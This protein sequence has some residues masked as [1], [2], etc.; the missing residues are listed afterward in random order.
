MSSP[1]F[2]EVQLPR[3]FS[4]QRDDEGDRLHRLRREQTHRRPSHAERS[5]AKWKMRHSL[6]GKINGIHEEHPRTRRSSS[7]VK[8]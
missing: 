3:R 6:T 8:L 2:G 7:E 4:L 1:G 5:Q